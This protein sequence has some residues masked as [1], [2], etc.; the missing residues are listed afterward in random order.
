MKKIISLI[1]VILFLLLAGC[2]TSNIIH[3]Y[4]YIKPN[5]N[6]SNSKTGYLEVFTAKFPEK[7]IY[8]EDPGLDVY[9]G[10]SIYTKEGKFIKDVKD[11][12]IKPELVRLVEGEYVVV[13][14]MY[15]NFVQS[16][17]ITIERGKLLTIDNSMV[18][19]PVAVNLETGFSKD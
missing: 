9:K 10:Y 3:R 2:S 13:A 5:T 19:K 4:N 14:E 1:F 17:K 15:E 7:G 11:S 12:Y 8:G 18:K 6:I 16:F